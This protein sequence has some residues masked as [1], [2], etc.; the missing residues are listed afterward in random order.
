M[1]RALTEIEVADRLNFNRFATFKRALDNGL[2]P[3]ADLQFPDGPRWSETT[4]NKWLGVETEETKIKA[5]EEKLLEKF[6][7]AEQAA[8]PVD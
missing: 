4:F 5:E 7:N 2:I 8:A 3:Q 6:R 1:T